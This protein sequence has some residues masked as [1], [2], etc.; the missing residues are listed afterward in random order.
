MGNLSYPTRS[1]SQYFEEKYLSSLFPEWQNPVQPVEAVN[2]FMSG[3][4]AILT[5]KA[6]GIGGDAFAIDAACAS[7]LYALKLGCDKLQ[8]GTE[9]MMLIGGVCAS[10]QLFLHVGFTALNALSPSGNSLPFN[11]N[12]NGLIPSEGAGFIVIKRLNDAIASNDKILGVIRGIGLSNDGKDGGFLSPSQKGQVRSMKNALASAGVE[13]K[14]IS[15]IECHATGTSTGDLIE[16]KSMQEVYGNSSSIHLSSL[17][18]NIGHTIT[19]SGVGSI[20]KVLGAFKNRHLPP[21]PNTFPLNESVAQCGFSVSN[22]SIQWKSKGNRIAGISNFGFG[23]NN[24]HVILEEWNPDTKY[25]TAKI[26]PK[27]QNVVAVV[28]VEV[29]SDKFKN[30]SDY[31]NCLLNDTNADYKNENIVFDLKEL[32]TP[33]NDLKFT[34]S[35]QLLMLQTTQQLLANGAKLDKESTGVFVGMGA[36]AEI[37][38]YVFRKRLKELLQKG[39]ITYESKELEQLEES[40]S[41]LLNAAGVLGTM[42]NIPANRINYHFDFTGTGFT[43]SCE[44]LSGVK[45]L[46]IAINAIQNNELSAAIVGAVDISDEFVNRAALSTV[47]DINMPLGNTGVALILKDYN[48]AVTDCDTIY[49]TIGSDE[50]RE[51]IYAFEKDYMM[52]KTG[53]SHASTGLLEVA[54]AVLLT[55][56][57]LQTYEYTSLKPLLENSNGFSY[58]VSSTSL[59][60]AKSDIYV[61]SQPLNDITIRST[62]SLL[63]H[64]YSG[65][66]KAS[67]IQ[68]LKENIYSQDGAYRLGIIS[69]KEDLQKHKEHAL[70]LLLQEKPI[71]GWITPFIH[72]RSE[73][74]EGELAFVFTGAASAYPQM[75][76]ELLQEFPGLVEGIEHCKNPDFAGQWIYETNSPKAK[77]PFYQLTGSSLMCQ[78]HSAFTGK[79]LGLKPDAVIGLSSGETNSMFALGVWEDMDSLLKGINE[80]ELYHSALAVDFNSVKEYWG[81][82]DHEK[83]HWENWRILAPVK[84]VKELLANEQRVYLTIVNT[85]TDCVIGGDKD[86]CARILKHIG[87]DKAMPLHHDIAVHCAPVMPFEKKWRELHTRKVNTVDGVRFYSNYLDGVYIP[88]T[89]TVADALT[90]QALQTIDFPKIVEKAYEDGVRIFVEHGPRNSLSLAI[91]EILKGKDFVSVS[92]DRFGQSSLAEAL[93][94]STELWCAGVPISIETLVAKNGEVQPSMEIKFPIRR[95]QIINNMA[96]DKNF[97]SKPNLDKFRNSVLKL[98]RAPQIAVTKRS[99]RSRTFT[100]TI[101]KE[102]N[103]TVEVQTNHVSDQ[104]PEFETHLSVN[105]GLVSIADMILNQH[106]VMA[107]AYENFLQV[108]L[109]AQK[110][111]SNLMQNM[112]NELI[113]EG[114][115]DVVPIE[116]YSN[117][118]YDTSAILLSDYDENVILQE[119]ISPDIIEAE[120]FKDDS[121]PL[122]EE[123]GLPG[124]KF[125]REQ[126]EIL[127]SGKISSVFGPFFK[128]QDQYDIQVRM[129]EPPLLL[130]DR[131][132]GIE[133]EPGT[134]KLGT[135]W[136][137]TDVT[138]NSWYLHNNRM[139]PGIFIE[140]GQA[141]LLLISYLGIDFQNKGERAYRLLGCELKFFGELPQP[142]DTLKYEIHVDGY[143]KSGETTLFFFHYDCHIDGKIRIS[144]RNGQAG[145]FTKEE[146]K[147]SKGIIWNP[148]NAVYSS[149]A[150]PLLK[151]PTKKKS[152]TYDE[153]V[154]YTLGDMVTCFGEELNWT[155]THTRTPRSQAGYQNFIQNV[156]SFDLEGGPAKRGYLKS[157]AI[158]SPDDWYFKGHFKNDPCMPGTLMADACLQMMAFY[159]VGAGL[160]INKDGWRFEPVTNDKFKFVCR[161]QVTPES[162]KVTYEIFVDE[163]ILDEHP[164]L[165]AHVLTTVDG[166]K[167]FLCERLGLKLVPDWPLTTMKHLIEKDV[168]GKPVASYKGF[169]FGYESLINCA[170]GRPL[171]AFGAD[172][173]HYDSG[174]RSPRLPGPPY[175]FMTRIADFDVIPGEMRQN[176]FVQA[177]YDIPADAWYFKENGKAAMPYAVLMEVALQPCGWLSTFFCQKD[178]KGK[179]VVFR[180]LDGTAVQHREITPADATI[181]TRTVLKSVSAMGEIIIVKFN[182]VSSV[183]GNPVFTM[184]TVFGFFDS[185]SM[186]SQKGLT[187]HPEEIVNFNLPRNI[188]HDLKPFPEKFFKTTSARLP[189]SKLLMIDRVVVLKEDGGKFGKGYIRSEKDVRMDEWFFKAHFFQDPV[190][191]GSLGVEAMLQL[192]QFYMLEQGFHVH[193][194]NP[195]FEPIAIKE[196]TE[197]HYRGQVTPDKNLISIDFDVRETHIGEESVTVVGEA[198]L[199]VDGL[200]IYHAPKI[201]MRL[202]DK[203]LRKVIIASTQEELDEIYRLRY[204]VYAEDMGYDFPNKN[205]K[206]ITDELDATGINFYL[207]KDKKMIG[208][209]RLNKLKMADASPEFIK[210]YQL[211]AFKDKFN[212]FYFIGKLMFHSD[213]RKFSELR[214]LLLEGIYAHILKMGPGLILLNSRDELLPLYEF[215]GFKLYHKP[216]IDLILGKMNPLF[217]IIEMPE[218]EVKKG[219]LS[220]KQAQDPTLKTY[221]I[222]HK[223]DLK[224]NPFLLDHTIG[225]KPVLPVVSSI[226]WIAESTANFYP[227]LYISAIENSKMFKG[228]VLKDDDESK[229]YHL[230]IKELEKSQ[231]TI[232]CEGSIYSHNDHGNKVF[233]YRSEVILKQSKEISPPFSLPALPECTLKES[234]DAYYKNGTLFHGSSFQGIKEVEIYGEKY[235]RIKCNVKSVADEIQGQFTVNQINPFISDVQY[236]GLLIWAKYIY[237][238]GS[239]PVKCDK[240]KVYQPLEFNKDYHVFFEMISHSPTKIV[241]NV[242]TYDGDSNVCLRS[243]GAEI[244][245]SKDLSYGKKGTIR[246]VKFDEV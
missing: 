65:E 230:E 231:E 229:D 223:L 228:I 163:I 218:Y 128:K 34:L 96:S 203:G 77:L 219:E 22:D 46:E 199:W 131:V 201:G 93:K 90:G 31:L 209:C 86:A 143:A 43:V 246:K 97:I 132:T 27:K 49:A 14:D 122:N 154:S 240:V 129:P 17:K 123:I 3:L 39:N 189:D 88:T 44:E 5:A 202:V 6:I 147:E 159:M 156:T 234:G 214:T 62:G 195:V 160:T 190:Q 164:I 24:A 110:E 68:S 208:V 180:N 141:D 82:Q 216:F 87:A 20:I 184:D 89:D 242:T 116:Q 177:E 76:R 232:K 186:K 109:N 112:A 47:L 63:I 51:N 178:I 25:S 137:E 193:L 75:G 66:D 111:F 169:K 212:E 33:P 83:V 168:T 41:S 210:N 2:R 241:A 167:A 113:I 38:R 73:K 84:K 142:G 124:P 15:Y 158:V 108:Q 181:T 107:E 120:N 225:G 173:L 61:H 57:R 148:E 191:P 245:I 50:K 92:L 183:N 217:Q 239:L 235:M 35:Q 100:H 227:G 7:S 106:T 182:V 69:S 174:A 140:A 165:Y 224:L 28:G 45:A 161:G 117:E 102:E 12:A 42:P 157:E 72:Y 79:I 196:E 215:M 175:H 119:T 226:A 67:L 198:R 194:N 103:N 188:N 13:P 244:T 150:L 94:A 16:I 237:N 74:I 8:K 18:G 53:Y 59:F 11:Q 56:H 139:P 23:G 238:A 55:R 60:G 243:E 4:P 91:H 166:T 130:C 101:E 222:N 185:E 151:S 213:Y 95:E 118:E 85:K 114:Q 115:R 40:I 52:S 78:V 205:E 121:Y 64:C 134:L 19:A 54:T 126:L 135:I 170:L 58:E 32:S 80:S 221:L 138:E 127:A 9:D 48:K 149:S 21:T 99:M 192:I 30:A 70:H 233:H 207:Q 236:Q 98:E 104:M 152:F 187:A 136:T 71:T 105:E 211:S 171:D 162:K 29:Q 81:L 10:D 37:N 1:F 145:F 206:I 146:L 172:F 220:Y 176:S 155:K 36:D 133:G 153:V 204:T 26:S 179:D 144:V 200:K 125:S 197:W